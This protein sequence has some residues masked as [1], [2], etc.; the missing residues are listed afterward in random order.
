MQPAAEVPLRFLTLLI[1]R[2][3]TLYIS[4]NVYTL[5]A[6]TLYLRFA[7]TSFFFSFCTFR[8]LFSWFLFVR[9]YVNRDILQRQVF[10]R[11][12][13]LIFRLIAINLTEVWR[14]RSMCFLLW[15]GVERTTWCHR[16][17]FKEMTL[18]DS[19]LYISRPWEKD[20]KSCFS[21]LVNQFSTFDTL[22]AICRVPLQSRIIY[23]ILFTLSLL[24]V[25]TWQNFP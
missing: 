18:R 22:S 15:P 10:L 20:H 17:D 7:V 16:C 4:Y 24:S 9:I 12:A 25:L 3:Y 2:D 11:G 6:Y 19:Q 21:F 5:H 8:S 14:W 23:A 1:F 13:T